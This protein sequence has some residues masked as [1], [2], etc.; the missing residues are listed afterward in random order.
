MKLNP[1]ALILLYTTLLAGCAQQPGLSGAT[2]PEGARSPADTDADSNRRSLT[3]DIVNRHSAERISRQEKDV[4]S[5]I[6]ADLAFAPAV[7][8][9][10][11]ARQLEWLHNNQSYFDRTLSR[12]RL[13]LPYVAEQVREAGLPSEVALLP[14]IESAYDPFAHSHSGAAGLWQFMPATGD[15]FNL[16][17]D[18]WYE[19]RRDL[20][21]STAAAIRYLGE[22]NDQ[23]DG[24][25]PLT[26]AAYN[27]GPGTVRRAIE[28]NRRRGLATDYWSL[29]LPRETRHYVPRLVALAKVIAAPAAFNIQY[30]S[31]PPAS[32]LAVVELDRPLELARAADLADLEVDDLY[33]LNPGYKRW[34]TPPDGPHRLVLPTASEASF[35]RNLE[36]APPT[37]WRFAEEYVVKKGDT[38]GRIARRFDADVAELR[39]LNKLDGSLIHAGQS[40]RVPVDASRANRQYQVRKGDSLWSIARR[41]DVAL[42]DLVTHN[43]L[44]DNLLKPGQNLSIPR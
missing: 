40:L 20:I 9:S 6:V 7:D 27:A 36:A 16:R 8:E 43:G 17:R 26:F 34:V 39:S 21:Q 5:L 24:D 11:V 19:G 18:R 32:G 22:L 14:F 29:D 28:R 44:D 33:H 12:A 3:I 30:P 10:R 23:F 25:W 2:R 41:F 15:G 13:Y 38:L 37:D 1:P 4:W 35:L 42:Q 31:L